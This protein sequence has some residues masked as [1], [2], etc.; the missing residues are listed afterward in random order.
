MFK[1]S[2]AFALASCSSLLATPSL[3]QDSQ[4]SFSGQVL[5]Q[6]SLVMIDS[7]PTSGNN[8][9]FTLVGNR[10]A[11]TTVCNTSSTL[12]VTIDKTASVLTDPNTKIRFSTG[13]TG[14]Y[15]GASL[16]SNYQD[17]ASYSTNGVTSAIGDT[18]QIET[19]S[20][21]TQNPAELIV[22]YASLT[23]Q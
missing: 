2:I 5:P 19:N 3:A 6:C 14:I 12:S 23:P 11:I 7:I 10:G 9:S 4:I 15:A 20:S 21:A 13:G 1:Y 8:A 16:N 18:A 17:T 22:V